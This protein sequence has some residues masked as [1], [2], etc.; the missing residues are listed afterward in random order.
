M[1]NTKIFL[2]AALLGATLVACQKEQ[3]NKTPEEQPVL[4]KTVMLTVQASKSVDTK[5]MA[6]SGNT[7]TAYW[8]DDEEVAVY[9]AG[10]TEP[11]GILKASNISTS[12][13]ISTATLSGAIEVTNLSEGS[14]NFTLL[15][16]GRSD[17]KWTYEGQ[18]GSEPDEDGSMAS[19]FDYTM[20][21]LTA[22]YNSAANTITPSGTAS[23]TNQ[24][25]IF[26]FGF[27][28]AMSS[29]TISSD[30]N[31]LIVSR[32]FN[33]SNWVSTP[34]SLV[35]TPGST[36]ATTYFVSIRNENTSVADRLYFSYIGTGNALYEGSQKIGVSYLGNEKF[37][38]ATITMGQKTFA[39]SSDPEAPTISQE[40]DVL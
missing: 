4:N 2:I 8:I 9:V 39:P 20:A 37:L 27:N 35:V 28:M 32:A 23:F 40:V 17:N 24:Q 18:D 38:G 5:A 21:T 25:S 30:Q 11:Q 34:G 10:A 22:T 16:P 3:D 7:L 12:D 1:K 6:L 36:V 13:G 29:F 15:F 33:G 26:R 19:S 14:N 31:Q